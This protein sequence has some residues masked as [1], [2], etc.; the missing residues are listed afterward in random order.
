MRSNQRTPYRV[1]AVLKA[2]LILEE[3]A[4][5]DAP[6]S[7]KDLSAR[8][9][10]PKSTVYAILATLEARRYVERDP[11]GAVRLGLKAFEVGSA[12]TRDISL[13]EAFHQTARRLVAES[14]ETIQLAILDGA[15]VVYIAREDGT[16]PVRLFS[17]V[18]KRLPAHATALGKVL[19]AALLDPSLDSLLSER[20]L[21]KLTART[22]S[23]IHKLK[24]ELATVRERG[25]A[26]DDEETADGLQ[27]LAAP[28][29]DHACQVRAAMSISVPTA[30]M[31][32]PRFARNLH[33]IQDGA[34]EVSE[35]L[36]GCVPAAA[37]PLRGKT[38]RRVVR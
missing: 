6:R 32:P 21:R 35:R 16:Q 23:S 20:P 11:A 36:G 4:A 30:R 33:L 28:I 9:C 3:L 8:T 14:G 2:L 7:L 25:Y 5:S 12:Y 17:F 34:R 10:L 13:T 15:D 18:G 1:P 37:S 26:H 22:I 24:S 31:D 38:S 27:C 29:F 19:L